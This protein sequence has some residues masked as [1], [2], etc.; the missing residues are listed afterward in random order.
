MEQTVYGTV[1]FLQ[2]QILDSRKEHREPRKGDTAFCVI[3][4]VGINW[5]IIVLIIQRKEKSFSDE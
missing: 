5:K 1:V 2:M 4:H 3:D